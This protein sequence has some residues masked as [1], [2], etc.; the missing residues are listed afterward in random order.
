MIFLLLAAAALHDTAA[1]KRTA[2]KGRKAIATANFIS[3]ADASRRISFR[4]DEV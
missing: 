1:G 4:H 2:T 3:S